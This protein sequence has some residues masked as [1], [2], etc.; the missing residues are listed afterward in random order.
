[1]MI[2]KVRRAVCLIRSDSSKAI[3]HPAQLMLGWVIL[4]WAA[5]RLQPISLVVA[6]VPAVLFALW[7]DRAALLRSFRRT[8]SLM[9][10]LVLIY[11]WMT[12]GL[13]LWS[14]GWAPTEEGLH[15]GLIQALRLLAF[16]VLTR[17]VLAL[18]GRDALMAALYALAYPLQWMGVD[19][20]RLA[21][22]LGLTLALSDR[23][24]ASRT[25]WRDLWR[26]LEQGA[27]DVLEAVTLPEPAPALPWQRLGIGLMWILTG[28]VVWL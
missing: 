10:A 12:P 20:T 3:Y 6:L 5:A 17:C 18:L 1:M 16:V 11:G 4:M 14:G 24:L 13:H 22:R 23:W 8:L 27:P 7:R 25:S 19:R 9:V 28:V 21:R 2:S 26:A 15:A